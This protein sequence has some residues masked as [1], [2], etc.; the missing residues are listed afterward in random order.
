[1][2]EDKERTLE[3]VLTDYGELIEQM[4]SLALELRA[5][6]TADLARYLDVPVVWA[7]CTIE[8]ERRRAERIN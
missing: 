6:E 2:S 7:L 5:F 1:M 4:E 8:L 3:A